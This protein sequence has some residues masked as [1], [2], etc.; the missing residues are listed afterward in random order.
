[1]GSENYNE[2]IID[3]MRRSPV[4]WMNYIIIGINIVVFALVE[5]TGSSLDA[6]HMVD[7]GA[8]YTPLI[9]QGEFYRLFTCMF[10][11]FGIE[12]LF[13]NMFLLFFVGY[14]LE[15]Y[16]GKI[17]YLIIYLGGGLLGS[18]GSWAM[19]VSQGTEIVS[20]GASGA[21]FSVLGALVIIVWHYRGHKGNLSVRRLLAM[22]AL[23]VYVGFRSTGVDNLAHVGG[24]LGGAFLALFPVRFKKSENEV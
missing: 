3:E 2:D 5:A 8:A 6:A 19:E 7:W 14:Y 18:L 21:I 17:R 10:L 15:Q 4:C 13:N 1:M 24:L 20:A 11:H 22:I 12:H 9:K 16:V 23:S